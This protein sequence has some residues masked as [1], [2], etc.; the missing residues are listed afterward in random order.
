MKTFDLLTDGIVAT[1]PDQGHEPGVI[2]FLPWGRR[3]EG[4]LVFHVEQWRLYSENAGEEIFLSEQQGWHGDFPAGTVSLDG[5]SV[6]LLRGALLSQYDPPGDHGLTI[7][8]LR[9]MTPR[10][11][12]FHSARAEKEALLLSVLSSWDGTLQLYWGVRMALRQQRDDALHRMQCWASRGVEALFWDLSDVR[13]ALSASKEVPEGLL[14]K[15]EQIA[16]EVEFDAHQASPESSLLIR[17]DAVR[18]FGSAPLSAW[19]VLPR[20]FWTDIL[21]RQPSRD[22][23]LALWGALEAR[24]AW[25]Q[26]QSYRSL[27]PQLLDQSF[28]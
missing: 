24:Q 18:P 28:C 11:E 15:T 27:T 21:S 20:S 13:M 12:I 17:Y 23:V 2:L 14:D 1:L 7:S 9:H 19:F 25:Q 4:S 5:P 10:I 26:S 8:T 3:I 16:G 22:S 6:A